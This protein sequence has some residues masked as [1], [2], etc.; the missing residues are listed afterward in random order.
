MLPPSCVGS[1]PLSHRVGWTMVSETLAG[2]RVSY[3]SAVLLIDWCD[4]ADSGWMTHLEHISGTAMQV[5]NTNM[6]DTS[7]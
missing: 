5:G 6:S 3:I 2:M 7:L 4:V 1:T